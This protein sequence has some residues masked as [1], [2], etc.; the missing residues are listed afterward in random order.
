MTN[1]II[2]NALSSIEGLE[3]ATI[4][5]EVAL[6]EGA[7]FAVVDLNINRESFTIPVIHYEGDDT[8]FTPCDWQGYVPTEPDEIEEIEWRVND[9]SHTAI[10]LGGLPRIFS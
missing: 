7:T 2:Y 10:M 8:I 1:Q 4:L 5:K 3:S 9:T 6:N